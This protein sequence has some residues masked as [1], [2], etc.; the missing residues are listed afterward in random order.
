MEKCRKRGEG[1]TPMTVDS[2]SHFMGDQYYDDR[3]RE[4]VERLPF[5]DLERDFRYVLQ[6]IRVHL[7]RRRRTSTGRP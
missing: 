5:A 1:M 4:A 7:P 6:A 2:A 3:V